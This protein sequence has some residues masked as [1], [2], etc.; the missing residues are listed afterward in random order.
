MENESSNAQ[1]RLDVMLSRMCRTGLARLLPNGGLFNQYAAEVI[2]EAISRS[3]IPK[4]PISVVDVA[5]HFGILPPKAR[6]RL[7]TVKTNRGRRA[8]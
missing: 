5:D 8:R 3:S 7:T 4:T 2:D 1:G 6:P